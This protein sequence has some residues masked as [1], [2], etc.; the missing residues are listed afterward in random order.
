MKLLPTLLLTSFASGLALA[1]PPATFR[2]DRYKDLYLKSAITDP[3]P[4]VVPE[5]VPTDL[6]DWTLVAVGKTRTGAPEVRI[7]NMKDRSRIT[8][9]SPAASEAG[10]AIV[11]IENSRNYLKDAVVT[12]KKGNAEGDVS[13]DTKYLVLKKVAAPTGASANRSNGNKTP[14][15]NKKGGVPLPPGTKTTGGTK[16]NTPPTPPGAIPKPTTS[17]PAG[18]STTST[19]SKTKSSGS[20]KTKRTRYVPRPK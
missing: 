12:L 18:A 6:P 15:R 16:A 2:P 8:I 20:T 5:D 10:F 19:K 7:M 4:P 13:F 11:N 14:D 17:K 3:P 1:D 9:P